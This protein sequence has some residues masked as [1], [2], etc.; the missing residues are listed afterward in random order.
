VILR[1]PQE[2]ILSQGS[3]QVSV[4]THTQHGEQLGELLASTP[5]QDYDFFRITEAWWDGSPDWKD[6]TDGRSLF[7]K[8]RLERARSAGGA[9]CRGV[10][11]A[12]PWDR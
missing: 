10:P 7:R 9:L 3:P 1:V 6:A 12:L 4:S 5:L 2:S 11:R 8:D